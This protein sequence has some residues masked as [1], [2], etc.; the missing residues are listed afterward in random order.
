MTTPLGFMKSLTTRLA[1]AGLPF[2]VTSGMACVFYGLQQT[3]KDVDIV[4]PDAG[5]PRV[6]DFF[7]ALERE[8][9]RWRVSYRPVFAAPLD[10]DYMEHGWTSHLSLWDE[11]N[12]AEHHLDIF[13]RPPRVIELERSAEN[14]IFASRHVVAMMK[15]TNRDRDWPIVGALGWQLKERHPAQALLHLQDPQ[16]LLDVW[17]VSPSDVR[18]NAAERRPLLRLLP[19]TRGV[20]DL[21]AWLRLERLLWETVNEERYRLYESAWRTFYRRWRLDDSFE[22]P[23]S[24]AIRAQHERL[25]EAVRRFGLERDPLGAAGRE[26]IY[27]RAACRAIVRADSTRAKLERVRPALQEVLP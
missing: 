17:E 24:E 21:S 13:C 15:R 8:M 6:L 11:P 7:E 10:R 1:D 12:S 20:D 22:W 18:T 9:P 26:E 25:R 2:A 14:P 23:T 3:T 19:D 16:S 5:E 27:E 4:L